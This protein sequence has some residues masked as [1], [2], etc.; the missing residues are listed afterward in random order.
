MRKITF[1]LTAAVLLIVS[2][3]SSA[4]SADISSVS[5]E[6]D[7]L[8]Y[9]QQFRPSDYAFALSN[10][11]KILA[12][13]KKEKFPY[14]QEAVCVVFPEMMRF[15][16]FQNEIESLVNE[17]LAYAVEESSGFSIGLFQMKP[18]FASQLE[19]II[20]LNPELRRKY[21]KISFN[22][23]V[24][25]AEAR[26]D[27]ILRL[28]DLDFQKEYIK[29]FVEFEVENLNLKDCSIEE[30]IR[31]L[32]TAYNAG[33]MYSRQSID[34]MS[35]RKTFPTGRRDIYVSYS[36]LCISVLKKL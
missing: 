15:S 10:A 6:P 5:N 9:F 16:Q 26:H 19:K 25:S 31:F 29:A 33:L 32:A 30:R 35:H 20:S 2:F 34:E 21:R 24:S 28:R 12:E 11:R 7:P 17:L 36:D 22:G 23:D 13:L 4:F 8:E 1:I 27:R 14:A 18:L 3:S